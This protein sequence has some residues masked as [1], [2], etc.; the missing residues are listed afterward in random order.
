VLAAAKAVPEAGLDAADGA[1]ACVCATTAP[2][3]SNGGIVSTAPSFMRLGSPR[4]KEAGFA[5]KI[6]FEARDNTA[7]SC[8]CVTAM[9]TS[10]SDCPGFTVNR[11]ADS[12]PTADAAAPLAG[13]AAK[14]P[15]EVKTIVA[16][17]TANTVAVAT[18]TVAARARG[19]SAMV[20]HAG[21]RDVERTVMCVFRASRRGHECRLEKDKIG[22]KKGAATGATPLQS[23]TS[24]NA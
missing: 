8:D 23:Y 21:A 7:R 16:S 6:A 12:V 19:A 22:R 10:F 9:A 13:S 3:E 1:W 2:V 5:S 15:G 17:A 4:M 14:A 11:V 18:P 20:R 24:Q